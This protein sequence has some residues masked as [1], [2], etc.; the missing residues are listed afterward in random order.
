V[1]FDNG[2]RAYGAGIHIVGGRFEVNKTGIFLGAD[3]NGT[4]FA[5]TGG[6]IS[7]ASMEANDTAIWASVANFTWIG[8]F[9]IQGS[10]NA[11][12]GHGIYGI[13][14]DNGGGNTFQNIVL[15]G[16]SSSF[17]ANG[18]YVNPGST[19]TTS[20]ISV[21]S[22]SQAGANWSITGSPGYTFIQSNNP[23]NAFAFSKLPSSPVEGMEYD[24]ND[25]NIA[26]PTSCT[27]WGNTPTSGGGSTHVH[28]RYNGR[29]WTIMGN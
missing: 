13:R 12:S 22:G 20:F 16:D 14:F 27:T 25:C 3:I 29:A 17:T 9:S 7:P 26:T 11:P 28:V 24:I 2:I 10:T 19:N 21:T 4:A 18:I 5:V 6:V 15:S 1:N 8:G 23:S